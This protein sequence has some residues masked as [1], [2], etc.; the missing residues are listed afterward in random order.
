MFRQDHE[1]HKISLIEE[2]F[3]KKF[4]IL[5]MGLNLVKN[6]KYT[7]IQALLL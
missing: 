5:K 6:S 7:S 2:G 1:R 3:L 4:K